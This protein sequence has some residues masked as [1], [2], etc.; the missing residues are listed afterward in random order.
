MSEPTQPPLGLQEIANALGRLRHLQETI[1]GLWQDF[2]A[3]V[4]GLLP[5]AVAEVHLQR[6]TEALDQQIEKALILAFGEDSPAL[7]QFRAVGFLPCSPRSL[8]DVQLLLD[9]QIGDL[10]RTRLGLVQSSANSLQPAP[11]MDDF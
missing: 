5:P 8:L 9:S 7:H 3:E 2:F 10:Q 4:P 1:E 11:V 6:A